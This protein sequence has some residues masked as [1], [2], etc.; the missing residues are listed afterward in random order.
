MILANILFVFYYTYT[1]FWFYGYTDIKFIYIE[2]CK[3]N[4]WRKKTNYRAIAAWLTCWF[5]SFTAFW[6]ASKKY[7]ASNFEYSD[8]H[9]CLGQWL[10]LKIDKYDSQA[11][12]TFRGMAVS[13]LCIVVKN[14][15]LSFGY[16]GK[17][18]DPLLHWIPVRQV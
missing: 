8:F 4:L 17:G 6:L 16:T 5:A 1:A 3:M 7:T 14:I 18:S 11:T 15:F 2:S 9:N 10:T 13:L 12:S